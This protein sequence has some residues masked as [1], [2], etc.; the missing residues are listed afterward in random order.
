M[1]LPALVI[2][3]LSRSRERFKNDKVLFLAELGGKMQI[4]ISFGRPSTVTF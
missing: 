4:P 1:T 2:N 3:S